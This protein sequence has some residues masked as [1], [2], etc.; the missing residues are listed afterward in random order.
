M[1]MFPSGVD[2]HA[3]GEVRSFSPS[4][5]RSWCSPPSSPSAARCTWRRSCPCAPVRSSAPSSV[6]ASRRRR[7]RLFS[8][9]RG[10]AARPPPSLTLARGLDVEAETP[11][12]VWLVLPPNPAGLPSFETTQRARGRGNLHSAPGAAAER[13]QV[14][15]QGCARGASDARGR[16]KVALHLF[17]RP[18]PVPRASN[19][20]VRAN[21]AA[22]PRPVSRAGL[23]GPAARLGGSV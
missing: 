6:G 1:Q 21:R 23:A 20:G 11:R 5:R 19:L 13:G 12:G 15:L 9:R 8:R 10:A 16:G 2:V 3:G 18:P 22:R 14:A 4:P 7:G 17:P